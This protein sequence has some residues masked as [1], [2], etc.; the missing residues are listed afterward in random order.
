MGR[1]CGATAMGMAK[2]IGQSCVIALPKGDREAQAAG[3]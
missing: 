3:D 2:A 1:C